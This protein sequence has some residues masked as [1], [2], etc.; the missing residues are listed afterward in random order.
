MV[1]DRVYKNSLYAIKHK[2]NTAKVKYYVVL[3]GASPLKTFYE[4][5]RSEP[6]FEGMTHYF[7]I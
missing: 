7:L 4:T 3:E 5:Y 2:K 1:M 6:R